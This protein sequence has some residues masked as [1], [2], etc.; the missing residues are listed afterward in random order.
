LTWL[1]HAL[2]SGCP[3]PAV[4]R[5]QDSPLIEHDECHACHENFQRNGEAVLACICNAVVSSGAL[6]T[7]QRREK[8]HAGRAVDQN[9]GDHAHTRL[10]GATVVADV[11]SVLIHPQVLAQ[12][13][14]G[15]DFT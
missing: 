8:S 14:Q 1:S 7:G 3:L 12:L 15:A 6:A 9:Q 5:L 2:S 4:L 10:A 13:Q 11:F